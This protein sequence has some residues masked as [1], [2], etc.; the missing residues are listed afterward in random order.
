MPKLVEGL[1]IL[2]Q[3]DPCAEYIV[4]ET[5]EHVIL[6]A[7]ELHLERCLKDLR[8][9]FAKCGIQASE[10]IVPFRETA[11]KAPDMAPVKTQGAARGTI[12]GS[13]Y[14]GLVEFT[15]R[16][17]PLP[18]AVIE[19]LVAHQSTIGSFLV[20][21]RRGAE[22]AE[23]D[24]DRADADEAADSATRHLTPEQFW[25]ELA[26]RFDEAGGE[27]VGAA[28][29]VWSFGPK[30]VG[31]NVLLDPMGKGALRLRGREA[32]FA[33][34]RREG[35]TAEQALAI[36]DAAAKAAAEGVE[37]VAAEENAQDADAD[38]RAQARL[39]R[40]FDNSIEAGF[41]RATFQ[42]P[43]CSEPVVGM[44]WVVESVEFKPDEAEQ[45]EC[46]CDPPR[47]RCEGHFVLTFPS[48]WSR[49]GRCRR[50]HLER[51]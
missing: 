13:V 49:I 40:D 31:A 22:D 16:A 50:A 10:A 14:D 48:S 23:D 19:F 26:T 28:D 36:A 33:E 51:A 45:G 27:W 20:Q 44:A 25:A 6:T 5:G 15:L 46:E 7:G 29:R 8:E 30:K 43:L 38:A 39:L 47:V 18:P 4:Q 2:N 41:Q 37:A 34:A 17:A 11:V 21:R 12:H 24:E 42:G 35:Q 3:A 9:R 1:Q 32:V